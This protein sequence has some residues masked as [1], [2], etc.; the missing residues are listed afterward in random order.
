MKKN[1]IMLLVSLCIIMFAVC[2]S[3]AG[4]GGDSFNIVKVTARDLLPPDDEGASTARTVAGGANDFAFRLG[5]ALVKNAGDKNFICSPYSVWLPLAALT[6]VLG[7]SGIAEAD[8]NKA[9]S[10]ML[11]SLTKMED[12]KHEK[13]YEKFGYKYYN[14]LKIANAIFVDKNVTLRKDF[15]Q[16][17][18]DFYRGSSINVD[19]S[20][21]AAVDAVNRWAS[22]NT[23]GLIINLNKKP[24]FIAHCY[25]LPTHRYMAL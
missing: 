8:I 18:M 23:D 10:R 14:P 20:S 19:F 17:F 21:Q 5:A 4:N 9:A 13:E 25:L 3:A 16:T 22:D 15:V 11:Y 1:T 2:K 12:K 6:T 7:A 24:P